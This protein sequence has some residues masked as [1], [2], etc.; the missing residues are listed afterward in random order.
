MSISPNLRTSPIS[1]FDPLRIHSLSESDS[2]NLQRRHSY[3]VH[4]TGSSRPQRCYPAPLFSGVEL[5]L[6]KS[7][8]ILDL[9]TSSKPT[10]AGSVPE[11]GTRKIIVEPPLAHRHSDD[12]DSWMSSWCFRPAIF[13]SPSIPLPDN[14]VSPSSP[15]GFNV[16]S[17]SATSPSILIGEVDSPVSRKS[18]T[19]NSSR[20]TYLSPS[21]GLPS[22]TSRVLSGMNKL[23]NLRDLLMIL[24]Q[25]MAVAP[26]A[27]SPQ[28][29]Q[30]R[31]KWYDPDWEEVDSMYRLGSEAAGT[32]QAF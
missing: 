22:R 31:P 27:Q 14:L 16:V 10:G 5:F 12:Y 32:G 21:T 28:S 3:E 13:K 7:P 2:D 17:P 11:M 25:T 29:P 15:F 23:Q 24:D 18:N 30:E 26:A 9:R 1:N 6:P 4:L 19:L 8:I 20:L